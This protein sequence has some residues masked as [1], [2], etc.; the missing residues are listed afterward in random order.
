MNPNEIEIHDKK[1]KVF[2]TRDEIQARVKEMAWQISKDYEGKAPIFIPV[3][4]GSF[5]F[6]ADL[7]RACKF[8]SELMFVGISSYKGMESTGEVFINYGLKGDKLKGK[9]LIIIEDI[10]DTGT[11][12]SHFITTIKQY[13][14]ASIAV[15][16]LLHKPN[17]IRFDIPLDYIG[18]RIPNAFVVGYGLDYDGLGRTLADVYQLAADDE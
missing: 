4:N 16:S 1:F 11:T 13:E 8:D 5:M 14:P 15:A 10:I 2:I 17:A 3:L 9:D 7:V 6:T 12:L 18:Y